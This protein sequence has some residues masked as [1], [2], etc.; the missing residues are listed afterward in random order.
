MREHLFGTDPRLLDMVKHLS[1]DQLKKM[2]LGGHD[3]IKVYNAY[4]AAVEHRGDAAKRE[5]LEQDDRLDRV[6]PGR[7]AVELVTILGTL[8]VLALAALVAVSLAAPSAA[9]AHAVSGIDYRFP[10]PIW[11]FAL[12]AGVAVL[13]SA[14]AAMFA[15]RSEHTWTGGDFYGTFPT[16]ALNGPKLGCARGQCGAGDGGAAAPWHHTGR[17]V[18]RTPATSRTT[19]SA[20]STTSG[21][22]GASSSA[23][24]RFTLACEVRPA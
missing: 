4:K 23:S 19:P 14:P 10:L 15:V 20:S 21:P 12:A 1:D 18:A 11:L 17:P 9:S 7:V 24:M 13:A 3:P 6:E 22:R 5:L 16:L 8:A 2:S